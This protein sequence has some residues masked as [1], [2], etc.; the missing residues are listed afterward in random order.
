MKLG[1][2][3]KY[4]VEVRDEVELA[5]ALAWAR[6]RGER[7]YVLGGGSNLVISDAGV[8]GLVLAMSLRGRETLPLADG[9]SVE[10]RACAGEPWDDVVCAAIEAGLGGLEA[11]SGI[12]GRTGATPV[13]NVGAYGQ[14]VK[15]TIRAVQAF[16]RVDLRRVT[17]SAAE[18]EFAYRDSRF[19]SRD[20]ERFIVTR[21]DFVL[22]RSERAEIRYPELG[23]A[24]AARGLEPSLRA[25]RDTVLELRRGKSM[26]VDPEDPN[27]RSCGSFFVNPVVTSEAADAAQAR[28]QAKDMPRYPQADGR[29]KLSAAYLIEHSGFAKGTRRGNV[30]ISSRHSLALVCHEGAHTEE[31]LDFA[32][33]VREVVQARTGIELSPEPVF[34]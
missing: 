21:V 22:T 30:G 4:F 24:L 31:L 11:L 16:D 33:H 29:I 23:R 14:E 26:L 17:L 20:R 15:D 19:K 2:P 28:L 18:C 32:R 13:Q 25:V 10:L 34:W 5:E 9:T 1:G 8:N 12:P 6:A 3:A 27:A 7:V